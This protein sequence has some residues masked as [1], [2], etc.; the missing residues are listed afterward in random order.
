MAGRR[1]RLAT[2]IEGL[3]SQSVRL[4]EKTAQPLRLGSA[5]RIATARS[6]SARSPQLISLAPI[7]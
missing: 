4:E 1:K 2:Q 3:G 7:V 5:A 6:G